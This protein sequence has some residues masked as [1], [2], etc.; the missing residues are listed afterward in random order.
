[1]CL[2][3]RN[4]TPQFAWPT[5]HSP[6][7]MHHHLPSPVLAR[8][9]HRRPSPILAR[10]QCQSTRR[11]LLSP[12]Q[13]SFS[14]FDTWNVLAWFFSHFLHQGFVFLSRNGFVWSSALLLR[15]SNHNNRKTQL[16]EL[17]ILIC[18][19]GAVVSRPRPPRPLG[20]KC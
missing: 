11:T 4:L 2:E 7:T 20:E 3:K 15:N 9:C 16:E 14:S 17:F 19:S 13:P 8:G 12:F 5:S 6:I 10:D 18:F 1:M